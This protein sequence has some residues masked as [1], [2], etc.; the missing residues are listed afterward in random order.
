MLGSRITLKVQ[1]ANIVRPTVV[2][3]ED[4]K[5]EESQ[6]KIGIKATADHT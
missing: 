4:I 6:L 1:K 2:P 3:K 5:A